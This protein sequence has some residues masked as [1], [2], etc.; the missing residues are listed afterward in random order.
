MRTDSPLE[1]RIRV[2]LAALGEQGL[3]RTLRAPEGVDLSSNDYLNLSRDPRLT[4]RLIDAVRREGCGST[5]S[6]LLRGEREC[7][8]AIERRFAA[9]KPAERALYFSTGYLANL[10]VLTTLPE[11]G[12]VVFSDQAN[13]TSIIDGVR[14]S[15]ARGVVFPHND[16]GRSGEPWPSP[17]TP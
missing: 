10:A 14:L 16:A 2:R 8:E 11:E 4:S 9:F 3:I 15:R 5:G 12:D 13:H 1:D 7:F 17:P 6:R